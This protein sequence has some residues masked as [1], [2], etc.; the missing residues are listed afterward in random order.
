MRL[1]LVLIS[2]IVLSGA[3]FGAGTD[4]KYY[5]E[6]GERL[7]SNGSYEEAVAAFD[8]SIAENGTYWNAWYGLAKAYYS[9]GKY[10][11][12]LELCDEVF[13]DPKA[14]QGESRS[15]FHAI[16]G[17][18]R[19]AYW[20]AFDQPP[21]T[22][23]SIG[24]VSEEIPEAYRIALARYEEA[25]ELNPNSTQAW[26][27]KGIILGSIGRMN[28]SIECFDRALSINSSHAEVWNN[29]GVSIDWSGRNADSLG[30]YNRA[31]DLN[32]NL[33]IALMNRAKTLST[34]MY[35]YSMARENASKA[36]ELDPSL[37]NE[38]SLWTWKYIY[39]F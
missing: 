27:S 37:K 7:L 5:Y 4:E 2:L 26:N 39:I 22:D 16:D 31:I 19:K 33:A 6:I 34:D 10:E 1:L 15:R 12:G 17:D 23:P 29:L 30:C 25:L 21:I 13:D 38:S 3:E 28:E 24:S 36:F 9:L 32:P 14:P 20:D 35:S 18:F 11:D 8:S